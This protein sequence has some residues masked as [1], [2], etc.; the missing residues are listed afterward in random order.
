MDKEEKAYLM[1]RIDRLRIDSAI[2]V[3]GYAAYATLGGVQLVDKIHVGHAGE[4][5]E[6]LSTNTINNNNLVSIMYRHVEPVCPDF[7]TYYGGVEHAIKVKVLSMATLFDQASMMYLNAFL[8][9]ILSSVHNLEMRTSS[10]S[11][12]TTSDVSTKDKVSITERIVNI[13]DQVDGLPGNSTKVH[14]I[15]E[16]QDFTIKL[17]DSDNSLAEVKV[18]GFEGSVIAKPAKTIIRSRLKD[19][20][21]RDCSAGAIYQNILLLQDDSL[22]DLKLVKYNKSSSAHLDNRETGHGLDYSVRLWLGQIQAA[23]LGKFYWEITRFFEPFINQEMTEA[24][25]QTA[26]DTVTKQ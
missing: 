16:L 9:S 1:F 18:K 12:M 13:T 17:T 6:V 20:S 7:A 22:F 26:M 21:I 11:V 4:Y 3:H 23:V 25:R 14:L 2:T 8:Q 19:L 15:A 24:A 10:S 5:M